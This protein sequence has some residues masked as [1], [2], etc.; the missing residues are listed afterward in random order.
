MHKGSNIPLSLSYNSDGI[1]QT[2][3][4]QG[5]FYDSFRL[6]LFINI[7]DDSG[8]ITT[9]AISA[10]I[11]VYPNPDLN[12]KMY[13][14]LTAND[15]RST[16]VVTLNSGNLKDVATFI[17]VF[18]IELNYQATNT[19]SSNGTKNGTITSSPEVEER[20]KLRELLMSKLNGM[21]ISDLSS[22]KLFSSAL[23][24][25]T[26]KPI[27]ISRNTAVNLN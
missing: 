9:Y 13:N 1:L 23:S 4:P 2:Q 10:P 6:Y 24:T 5:A 27:E 22:V 8:G 26:Q 15:P 7:I 19:N 17:T 18:S 16:A 3:L 20:A 25:M 14:E 12:S 21:S 11:F